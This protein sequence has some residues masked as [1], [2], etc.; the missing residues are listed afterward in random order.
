MEELR[1]ANKACEEGRAAQ[2]EQ[3]AAD[4]AQLLAE[5]EALRQQVRLTT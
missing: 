2:A 3:E 4:K 1:A 5:I